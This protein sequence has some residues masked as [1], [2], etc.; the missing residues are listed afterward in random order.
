MDAPWHFNSAQFIAQSFQHQLF[1]EAYDV[2]QSFH[3]K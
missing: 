1:Q 3:A 2:N